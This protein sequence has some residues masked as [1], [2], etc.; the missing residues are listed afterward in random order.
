ML[1]TDELIQRY[2]SH[3]PET[4]ATLHR[5]LTVLSLLSRSEGYL[6]DD[7]IQLV[8]DGYG[9]QVEGIEVYRDLEALREF[10]LVDMDG[11]SCW[12]STRQTEFWPFAGSDDQPEPR[13]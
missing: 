1:T 2:Y 7:L 8:R 5:V 11:Y 13:C 9:H 12:K 3:R 10:G 4:K 6:A